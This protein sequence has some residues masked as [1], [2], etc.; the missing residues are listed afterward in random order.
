[1]CETPAKVIRVNMDDC[2][3]SQ[4]AKYKSYTC[5]P[6]STMYGQ[7][8]TLE[9]LDHQREVA[10]ERIDHEKFDPKTNFGIK[11]KQFQISGPH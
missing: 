10:R 6:A 4:T 1:M 11:G 5:W 7:P 3:D 9:R 2:E 8:R